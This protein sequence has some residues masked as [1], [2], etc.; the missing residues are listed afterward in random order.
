MK[1][2]AFWV[3][4]FFLAITIDNFTAMARDLMVASCDGKPCGQVKLQFNS[5]SNMILPGRVTVKVFDKNGTLIKKYAGTLT[6]TRPNQPD[7]KVYDLR[8]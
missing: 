5:S 4:L 7:H 3:G 8:Q 6:K 1:W 2:V